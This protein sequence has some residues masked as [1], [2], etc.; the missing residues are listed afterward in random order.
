MCYFVCYVFDY[1]YIY[2]VIKCTDYEVYQRQRPQSNRLLFVA[3]LIVKHV[4][5]LRNC[6]F[7]LVAFNN[8]V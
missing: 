5:E 8:Q 3:I 7:Q 4:D 2:I 1:Q 6:R